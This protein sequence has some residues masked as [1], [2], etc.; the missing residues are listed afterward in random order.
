MNWLRTSCVSS[1]MAPCA[2]RVQRCVSR[3][4]QVLARWPGRAPGPRGRRGPGVASEHHPGLPIRWVATAFQAGFSSVLEP[5]P[6]P[7]PGTGWRGTNR[8]T[9]NTTGARK[10]LFT[11]TPSTIMRRG[12]WSC[13]GR[14]SCWKRRVPS[15]RTSRPW[16][17][18]KPTSA[19]VTCSALAPPGSRYRKRASP[20]GGSMNGLAWL[21]WPGEAWSLTRVLTNGPPRLFP[22]LRV[23]ADPP[24]THF[25]VHLLDE[26]HLS[27]VSGL[28][29]A[30]RPVTEPG[31]V[32]GGLGLPQ[33]KRRV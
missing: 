13:R 27:F 22:E 29:Q 9:A 11:T 26:V 30:E 14:L 1:R 23:T 24:G 8:V 31:R 25:K 7:S 16:G 3:G 4:S 32:S 28:R 5:G 17:S 15:A 33:R 20:P 18:Q 19:S 21:T 6:S 12:G 10:R 2:A